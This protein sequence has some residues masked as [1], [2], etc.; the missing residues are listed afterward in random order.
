MECSYEG[1]GRGQRAKGLCSRHYAMDRAGE[2]LRPILDRS[3]GGCK[4]E[5]C[6][7]AH[8]GNGYCHPHWS[9]WKRTGAAGGADIKVWNV[10]QCEGPECVRTSS[11]RGLCPSHYAQARKGKSLTVLQERGNALLPKDQSL[12]TLYSITLADYVRMEQEQGGGCAICGQRNENGRDLAVDH[13]HACCPGQKSCGKC[14]RA[15][16]C[17]RCNFAIGLL[18]DDTDLMAKAMEYVKC[19][20]L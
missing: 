1:C 13:D 16:L 11:V 18:R 5:Q 19:H 10:R 14:V 12:R 3:R 7:R 9:R 8:Y 2:E 4:V 17:S 15:L 6:E 20:R